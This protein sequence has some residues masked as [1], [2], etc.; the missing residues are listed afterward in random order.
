MRRRERLNQILSVIVGHGSM[1]VDALARQFDVSHATIRR[2]LELLEQQRLVSRTR[3]GAT[4]H[5]AFTDM[6]L[7]YKT[8]Q[9]LDEKRRI[10]HEAR[11]H[12]Q[13]ARVVGMT[14]GTT[15]AEFAHLLLDH[16]GLTVVT[17]ALNVALHLLDNPRLR[18]FVGG[19]ELRSSSQETV[20]H[21][22]EAF[23]T[24]YNLDVAF[25][26]VDGVDASA[27]CTN[28]DPA[29]ARANGE[30]LRRARRRIVLAD[31]AKLGRLALAQVCALSAVDLLITDDRADPA[32]VER[33]R[34]QGPEVTL[35]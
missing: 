14:G 10:A 8:A 22:T 17:N 32:Q 6:P 11:R 20:G 7:N 31:A 30:L 13:G 1:D 2:D 16:E 4:T 21:N 19:G 34:E 29:G 3:G 12:V 9:D 15:V 27:G 35:V 25:L 23:F 18:V 33:I 24:Q 26:G 28:Y 5:S